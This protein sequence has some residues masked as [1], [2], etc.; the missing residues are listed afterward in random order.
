MQ[1]ECA[2]TGHEGFLILCNPMFVSLT[3][4]LLLLLLLLFGGKGQ[5]AKLIKPNLDHSSFIAASDMRNIASLVETSQVHLTLICLALIIQ[6]K[7]HALLM[8][9][10]N[11]TGKLVMCFVLPEIC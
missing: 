6:L 10:A 11:I 9:Q 5:T 3:N 4:L 8:L 7:A 2:T 1:S